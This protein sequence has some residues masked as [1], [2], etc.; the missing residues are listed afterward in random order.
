MSK[1]G[2]KGAAPAAQAE[3][4]QPK[5]VQLLDI[6]TVQT[7]NGEKTKI[8]LAKGVQLVYDGVPVDFGEYNSAF[9]KDRAEM[10]SDMEFFIEKGLMTKEKADEEVDFIESKGIQ[11]KLQVANPKLK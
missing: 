9:M 11:L 3:K 8:Q 2:N 5:N 1:F 4:K 10:E 7:S 6:R